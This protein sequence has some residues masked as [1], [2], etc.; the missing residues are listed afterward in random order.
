[1][2]HPVFRT[3][4]IC[5]AL[6]CAAWL[7][8]DSGPTYVSEPFAPTISTA[9]RDLPPI[10]E[11]WT[12]YGPE[13]ARRQDYGFSGP[14]QDGKPFYN[15]LI[16]LQ[17]RAPAPDPPQALAFGTP[18]LNFAGYQSSSS[19]PDTT[20]DVGPN[21]FVQG[22]NSGGTS[23]ARIFNKSGTQQAHFEL[24]SLASGSPCNTGYCDPIVNYDEAADRWIL[25]EFPSSGGHLCVYVS[26]TPDPTGTWYAYQFLNVET[27]TPDYPKYG[28]WPLD[29]NGDGQYLEG[30]YLIG[31]NAGSGGRD[32][33]ALDRAK[34]LQ[35]LPATFMKFTPPSLSAFGFQ[36]FL[37]GGHEGDGLPPAGNQ[38]GYFL[39]PVDTEIHTGKSCSPEPCDIMEIY[40]VLVDWATPGNSVMTKLPDIKIAEYDHTLCGSSGNWNCMPQ[41]GTSQ[42]IDP[43]R[44]PLHFPLQYR[45]WGDYQTL[46]GCFA[47]DVGS[48]RAGVHWFEMRKTGSGAWVSHQEG[49]L[50]TT[51]GSN[52]INRS[53]CS[54]AMDS[55]G[56]IAVGYT[57]TGSL[58]PYYPSI[59][60]AGRLATDPLGTMPYYEYV[61]QDAST[62]KTNNERWGDYAGI[63]VD[64]SDGC[65]FWFVT[66]Y[67][68]SGQTK[69]AAFKFDACGCL[70]VPPAPTASAWVPGDNE[71]NISWN[72]SATSTI[73]RYW[74]YRS[75]TAGGPYEQI[76]EVADDNSPTYIY[77]DGT[78]SGGTRYYYVVKSN[79][80]AACTSPTSSEVNALATGACT[81]SP[82]F[83]GIA[84]VINPASATCILNLSWSSG[85]SNCSGS[86]TYNIY[87]ST[88]SGFTPGEGN[89]IAAG[90]T[91]TTYQ[92]LDNLASGTTY[93]YVV[94]SVDSV[95]GFEEANTHEESGAP[96]GPG[97]GPQTY[98]DEAF[99]TG[100]PPAGWTIANG[101][102]GTQRWTTLNPGGRTIP[103]GMTAPIEIIDSDR[104]GSGVSQ[105]DSLITP[106]FDCTG[107]STVT[108]EF[109]TYYYH[110]S[111]SVAY[112]DV[113]NNNGSTWTTHTSWTTTV[114]TSST[115]SHRTLDI[116]ALAGTAA[117]VKVRFRYTG[118][119]GWYWM[120]DNV[121]VTGFV[122]VPCSTGSSCANNPSL[123]SVIPDGPLTLCAGTAQLLS[124]SPTGG[125][126]M[127]YQWYD[128]LN[129]IGGATASTYSAND[130]GTHLYNCHIKGS[131]CSS[132]MS[133]ALPTQITW[134]A[135][136]TFVGLGSVTNP[137]EATCTL[138]LD[139]DAGTTPCPGGVTY[140]VYR[141][142][143]PGFTPAIGNRIAAGVT[144]TTYQD[145]DSLESG[146][147][148]YY[149]TR[150][151]TVQ[152]GIEETNTVERSGAP[153]GSGGGP[154]TALALENFEGAWGTY[155]DNPPAGWTIE[156]HGSIPGTWNTNDWYRYNKGGSYGYIARVNYSP[157]ENQDE[158]LITPAF[159]LPAG[160][161]SANLEYDHYFYVYSTPDEYGY[162]D[163]MSDQTPSWTNLITYTATTGTTSL[164]NH[165]TLNLL[166]YAGQTNCK[167]R[168]R[169]V[170]QDDWYWELDNVKVTGIVDNP[171]VTGAPYPA[172]VQTAHWTGGA[173]AWAADP[174]ATNGYSVFRGVPADLPSLL[175]DGVPDACLRAT[176]P[177]PDQ[178][179][180]DLSADDPSG[181]SGGF[182]WYLIR[183]E[184]S[185]GS[186][187]FGAA[188]TGP[189][190][191]NSSGPC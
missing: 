31:L 161:S 146:T 21:H 139:W 61:I 10:D 128:G 115:A 148:Y 151:V 100:D 163:F 112:I 184:G 164:Y 35:G 28:V 78:V 15:P 116:T 103:A 26:T 119:Y 125:V 69:I 42:K 108:L 191:L 142:T 183:G 38:P 157:V 140:N 96:F 165:G 145:T 147:P 153:T 72:D 82:T 95:N 170:A 132:A 68:G 33:V 171:C 110:Y 93:Y 76:A 168:F 49:V 117:Q 1:M 178:T 85:T 179:S 169:Y 64:P 185:G 5:L 7:G 101:G 29:T 32:L 130:T 62:S 160:A 166:P 182:Y 129:P 63:G 150:A 17:D 155:G 57:R 133:D 73:T 189:R 65:T 6:A 77:T 59:Y 105:D 188:S 86:V 66:E 177:A 83:A 81:L 91:G 14:S 109:D 154:F 27:G 75:T 114:G 94:R 159:N 41:P 54:A 55:S 44:E 25:S 104:D 71:I 186:G 20:G 47:E 149:K 40:S 111:G 92:D 127:T 11:S 136:P 19:P 113:S 126:G 97:G 138:D 80:G 88:T 173:L 50:A 90:V 30:S 48:D 144:G 187:P 70:A 36:L 124:A 123:V 43:I 9:V 190:V 180:V 8:A 143:S 74:V 60:Y 12:P 79:D 46:V 162:V 2:N 34:M 56:N 118:T 102:T 99:G 39:R 16:D 18:I 107:A 122:P 152:N 175:V 121:L 172:A 52:T 37:P 84:S 98:I 13:A 87:R 176:T 167:V 58:A 156:D 131:G 158:W 53:V 45:N 3:F 51:S 89:R 22:S 23:I 137:G 24:D 134:Q 135:E 181:V 120:V 174:K 106:A 4:V 67:G 141:D